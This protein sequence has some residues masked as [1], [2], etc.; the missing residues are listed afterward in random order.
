MI[1]KIRRFIELNNMIEPKDNVVIGL[2]GGADSV[3]LLLMLSELQKDMDFSLIAVHINHCIRGEEADRD[4]QFSREICELAEV[5]FLAFSVD[6]VKL[7]EREKLSLEEAGR[8]ARYNIFNQVLETSSGGKIAVAHHMDDQGETVLMNMLRGTGIKGLGG[9]QP[10]RNNI[11]RPLLCVRRAQIEAWLMEKGQMFHTDST[12]LD[13]EYTRNRLR[14]MIIPFFEN[15]IN[16][17]SVENICS[18]A[19]L[20]TEAESYISRMADGVAVSC[21]SKDEDGR[22]YSVN[23]E[24]LSGQDKVI[25]KY[26]IRNLLSGMVGNLRDISRNHVEEIMGLET[27][28]VG[29]RIDLPQGISAKRGYR[30]IKIY[31]R[32]DERESKV[33]VV[34]VDLEG[35][36]SG[37]VMLGTGTYDQQR[38]RVFLDYAEFKKTWDFPKITGNDYAKMFDC[39]KIK[40]TLQFRTRQTGDY[41]QIDENGGKKK[42]K[43]FFIDQKVPKECRDK[44]LLLADGSHILWIVGYRMSEGYKV[45]GKTACVLQMNIFE[46]AEEASE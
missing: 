8:R 4:E 30:D 9:I 41:I 10:V 27:M 32:E 33:K 37:T 14:N 11:I 3:C 31:I 19:E 6:V 1:K 43:D 36:D 39:D 23:I 46:L 45:T 25:R 7:A 15:S 2:S 13:N 26:V 21:I 16:P 22:S 20:A 18:L 40:F 5:P 24:K 38:G 28:K 44:V 34:T 35:K 17:H 12:N 29:S 42:L